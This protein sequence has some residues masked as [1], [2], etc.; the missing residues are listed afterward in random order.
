LQPVPGVT[1]GHG[2]DARY[3]PGAAGVGLAEPRG[4]RSS[5]SPDGAGLGAANTGGGPDLVLDGSADGVADAAFSQSGVNRPSPS[6]QT[7]AFDNT[8]GGGMTLEIDGVEVVTTA[9]DT[10]TL[11]GLSC[12][13]GEVAKWNGAS[14]V[15]APVDDSPPR[16]AGNQL[17]LSG[18]ALDVVEGPGSGLDADS[19]DGFDAAFFAAA[20]H[21]HDD[22]YFTENELSTSGAG[23]AVHWDNLSAV[24]QG[25]AD[26][27]D[28]TTN[29]TPGP[30]LIVEGDQIL[31]DPTAFSK[32]IS[33]LDSI[34]NVGAHSSLAIGA[35]GLGVISYYSATNGN[36]KLAFC[37]NLL[38]TSGTVVTRD[39]IGDV[40]WNPSVAIG[41]DGFALVSYHDSTNGDLKVVHLPYGL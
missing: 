28:D 23:G 11:A 9:T 20:T 34:G 26:G 21:L 29:Y 2:G 4:T 31:L 16:D 5:A 35:D 33:T 12:T 3:S 27:V 14:W 25:F 41:A 1:V 32:R 6:P 39:F 38:C 13:G 22:R 15:C 17:N 10:D 19:L 24:P 36:L 7:F 40:G 18:N 37:H 30:G 8:G